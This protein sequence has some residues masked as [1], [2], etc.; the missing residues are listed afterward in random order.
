MT[1]HNVI[2][3]WIGVKYYDT[4]IDSPTRDLTWEFGSGEFSPAVEEAL[5]GKWLG[6]ISLCAWVTLGIVILLINICSNKPFAS[7]MWCLICVVGMKR[8]AI[9]RVELPS[10]LVFKARAD[11]QLP[12]PSEKNEEGNRYYKRLFKT[13]ATLLVEVLVTKI[14]DPVPK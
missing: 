10:T 8:S 6:L 1:D 4:K 12:L 13:D 3:W 5:L 11:K 2:Y 7:G 14:V 9:R